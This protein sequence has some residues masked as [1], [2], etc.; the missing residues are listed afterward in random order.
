[1]SK[2]PELEAVKTKLEAEKA[3]LVKKVAPL[4]QK[5]EELNAKVQPLE[6]ELRGVN[7]QIKALEHPRLAELDNQLSGIAKAMG[8]KSITADS[9]NVAHEGGEAALK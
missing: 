3:E 6:A 5:R 7:Q 2:H 8:A 9:A 1:M 4:R